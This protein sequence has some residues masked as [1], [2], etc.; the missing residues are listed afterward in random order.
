MEMAYILT[1]TPSV[2]FLAFST[3]MTTLLWVIHSRETHY[4]MILYM[5]PSVN[6]TLP[7]QWNVSRN[8]LFEPV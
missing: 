5:M 2:I 1:T 8:V 4:K 7:K 6:I 3:M